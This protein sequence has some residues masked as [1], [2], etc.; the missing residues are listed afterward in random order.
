[1]GPD[2]TSGDAVRGCM[3][4]FENDGKESAATLSRR[5]LPG[6]LARAYMRSGIDLDERPMWPASNNVNG[7]SLWFENSARQQAREWKQHLI[8]RSAGGL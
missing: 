8:G 6:A 2:L 7:R 1:M 4:W 3:Y 5:R